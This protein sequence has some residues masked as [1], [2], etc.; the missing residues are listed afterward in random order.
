MWHEI[1]AGKSLW[2]RVLIRRANVAGSASNV[3]IA[4]VV[5]RVR[6]LDTENVCR[7]KIEQR[8]I[9]KKK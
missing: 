1:I 2:E 4:F 7:F 9:S 3:Y 5:V 8:M 6:F